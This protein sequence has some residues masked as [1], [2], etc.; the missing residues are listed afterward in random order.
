MSHIALKKLVHRDL[1]ARNILMTTDLVAKIADFGLARDIY[2]EGMYV[3]TGGGRL[4]I[5][6]MAPDA[7]RDQTYTIKSDVWSFGILLWEIVTLGGSPYPGIPVNILLEK[8]LYGYR[9]PKPKHCSD[10]VY[11]IMEDCWALDPSMRPSFDE[12]C[13]ALSLLLSEEGHSYINIRAIDAEQIG[14]N[15]ESKEENSI[16]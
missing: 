10:E 4:P 8:L 12:L 16:L 9:M 5:K 11:A 15:S 6:W 1:A 7:I 2:C 3:K 14:G 13:K